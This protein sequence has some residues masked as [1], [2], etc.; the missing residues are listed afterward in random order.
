MIELIVFI[1]SIWNAGVG[2][3]KDLYYI[4]ANPQYT[5]TIKNPESS[6]WILLTRHI[7]DRVIFKHL[8]L[9]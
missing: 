7:V 3:V 8:I 5:L 2:P 9:K 1:C 4:G 6:T